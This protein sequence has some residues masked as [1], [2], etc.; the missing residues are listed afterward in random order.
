MALLERID[1]L[2]E[3]HRE[4]I[5]GFLQQVVRTPSP[6][7]SEEAVARLVQRKMAE[8]GLEVTW[9]EAA[10][11]RPN[12]IGNLHGDGPGTRFL[13]NGHMDTVP[14]GPAAD[15]EDDPY[16]GRI[17][18]GR[19]YGRGACDMKGGLVAMIFATGL[20]RRLGR[21]P[22]GS[23]T[24]T[25][26][27]DEQTGS[28]LGT[29]Y[30]IRQ[31]YINHDMAIVGEPTDMRID[32]GHKGIL[33]VKFETRGKAAHASRPWRGVNAIE[34]MHALMSHLRALGEKLQERRD[35]LL[36]PATLNISMIEGGTFQ[37]MVPSHCSLVVD[38][39]LVYGETEEQALAE[40]REAL[41]ACQRTVPG[42]QG[43]MHVLRFAPAMRV[44][45]DAPVVLF[46]KDAI[47]TVTGQEPP[48]R[49]KDAGTDATWLTNLAGIPTAIFGAGDYRSASLAANEFIDLEDLVASVKVYM[50]VAAKATGYA[51]AAA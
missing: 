2:V 34:H 35:P 12:V 18:D 20:L 43:S 13:F 39:R 50:L 4:E 33:Q 8:L 26:V 36:G 32:V 24:V 25:A 49:G 9:V 21:P 14:P 11:G 51:D 42:W 22:R 1:Q 31:G 6:T 5:I 29:Q 3:E 16:S 28:D 46:L 40:F 10:P 7:G 23:V 30:L 45:P 37:N 47:R 48:V 38:R 17:V 15:W 19:L 41:A 44:E 27:C